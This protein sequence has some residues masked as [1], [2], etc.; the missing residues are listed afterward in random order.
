M[1]TR[2]I[3][4]L[5]LCSAFSA[6]AQVWTDAETLPLYGKAVEDTYTRYSRLPAAL[7]E[8]SRPRVWSLGQNSAGL[9]VRFRT[10]SPTL[11]V[12]WESAT[13][14]VMN[15]MSPT[16]SRGLDLYVRA[17]GKWH[18][19]AAAKPDL[20]NAVSERKIFQN[21]EPQMREY[22]LYLSLYDGVSSLQIGTEE[23]HPALQPE[24]QSPRS[25]R[26]IVMYGTSITQGGCVSRPGM[27]YTS[28]MSRELD[29]EFVNLG[30]SGNALLDLDIARLMA[31]V[32][33]PAAYV[34][35]PLCN[36]T[37]EDVEARG[38]AFFRILRDAHPDVP[39]IFVQALRY[40]G[41]GFD[42]E[43]TADREARRQAFKKLFDS[44]K[45]SGEKK[46]YFANPGADKSFDDAESSVDGTHLTD[47]GT[48]RFAQALLPVLK[49]ALR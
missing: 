9:Y 16:G 17:D 44:L 8:E 46:I 37:V 34:L 40:A 27:V 19:L 2:L 15:H 42:Q 7:K 47:L 25:D 35:A 30:F 31:S 13:S 18:F 41:E 1:K 5:L 49:K 32:E 10:D 11:W 14:H 26:P 23:G 29:R 4:L 22:M 36:A 33:H 39:I 45:K 28:I 3:L 6:R 20:K 24:L 48:L 38:E 21:M 43:M 12:R